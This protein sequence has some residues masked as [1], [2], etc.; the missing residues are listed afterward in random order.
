MNIMENSIRLFEML[1]G[2]EHLENIIKKQIE[3]KHESN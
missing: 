1:R 2:T 3:N